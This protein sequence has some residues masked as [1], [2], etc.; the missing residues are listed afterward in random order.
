MKKM[1]TYIVLGKFTQQGI[2][3]I[4]DSPSRLEKARKVGELV[5][6]TIEAFYYTMGQYDFVAI[7]KAPNYD[8]VMKWLFI[9]GS[10]GSIRTETLVATP[11]KEAA[12]IIQ[13]LP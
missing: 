7:C 9:L 3:N 6:G 4:K 8:A 10:A 11:A 1:P 5:G 12:A 13:G 2:E